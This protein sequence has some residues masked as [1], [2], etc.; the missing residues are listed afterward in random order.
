MDISP[1]LELAARAYAG[2]QS[3]ISKFILL[4]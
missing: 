2:Q 1:W 3:E 4:T